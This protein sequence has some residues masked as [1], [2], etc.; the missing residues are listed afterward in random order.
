MKNTTR[1]NAPKD[2]AD[3][4]RKT[5]S[6][7]VT[8]ALR[9]IRRIAPIARYNPSSEAVKAIGQTLHQEVDNVVAVLRAGKADGVSFDLDAVLRKG[10]GRESATRKERV[11]ASA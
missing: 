11:A 3:K 7:K 6:K 5:A 10:P 2:A 4:L 8:N 1:K 9:G